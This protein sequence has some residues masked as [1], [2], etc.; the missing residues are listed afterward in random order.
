MPWFLFLF[1]FLLLGCAQQESAEELLDHYLQLSDAG[2]IEGFDELLT[3]SALNSAV[4]ANEVIRELELEQVGETSFHSFQDLGNGEY[5]FCLDV[6]NTR[7]IDSSGNDLTP[8]QRPP[9][10]PMKMRI[11]SFAH[12]SKISELDIRRFSRC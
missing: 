5:G 10:V 12:G 7:L 4:Q 8:E 1:P 6:S 9:Q 11:E 2:A 3:G